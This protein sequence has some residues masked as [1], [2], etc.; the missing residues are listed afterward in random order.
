MQVK[1]WFQNRRMKYKRQSEEAELEMKS[2]KYPYSSFVHYSSMSPFYSYMPMPY[3]PENG[4]HYGYPSNMRSP[5]T[6]TATI[7][8]T[9][10][11]M[12][13]NSP[14]MIGSIPSPLSVAQR[15]MG[16]PCLP[17]TN[18][19]YFTNNGVLTPISPPTSYQQSYFLNEHTSLAAPAQ[20]HFG[21][22]WHRSLP[23][24]PTP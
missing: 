10:Q 1:T 23:T 12:G 5:Q 4:M 24:P 11:S 21:S 2:P 7:D 17:R 20:M 13:L 9:F 22:D 6:P 19:S 16:S 18:P 3:K 8:P 14:A 15:P